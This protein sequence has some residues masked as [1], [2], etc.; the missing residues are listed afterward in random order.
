MD[1][2]SNNSDFSFS[3]A[4][5]SNSHSNSNSNANSNHAKLSIAS[6]LSAPTSNELTTLSYVRKLDGLYRALEERVKRL[7]MATLQLSSLT[8]PNGNN[9]PNHIQTNIS[10]HSINA[11]G[12]HLNSAPLT[13]QPQPQPVHH[14]SRKI[15]KTDLEDY[16][17]PL[18]QKRAT[19]TIGELN[20]LAMG[21]KTDKYH[22][23]ETRVILSKVKC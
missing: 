17:L 14:S 1:T 23:M 13:Q 11:A 21:M 9:N 18:L 19:P 16:C 7:E 8:N 3:S 12:G 5:N 4:D 6:T 20:S 2:N 15:S 22:H 10:A